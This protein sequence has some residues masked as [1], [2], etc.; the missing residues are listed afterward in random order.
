MNPDNPKD[1]WNPDE[2]I[3]LV[4][5]LRDY[6]IG[7]A[8]GGFREHELGT[9]EKGK[10][11]DVIVLDRNLFAVPVEEIKEAKVELTVMDGEVV[12]QDSYSKV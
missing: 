2:K 5:A 11:A 1:G 9:L 6:T 10:L 7:S 8:Y 12:F 4:E 3:I